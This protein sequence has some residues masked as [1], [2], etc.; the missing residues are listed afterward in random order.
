MASREKEAEAAL[1]ATFVIPIDAAEACRRAVVIANSK[2]GRLWSGA[3][4]IQM[5]SPTDQLHLE[6]ASG[7]GVWERHREVVFHS[8]ADFIPVLD[9]AYACIDLASLASQA[10]LR[11]GLSEPSIS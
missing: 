6:G 3:S 8:W 2:K 4:R 7:S 11:R 5:I 1:A 9:G 10:G